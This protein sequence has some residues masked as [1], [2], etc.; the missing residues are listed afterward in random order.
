[1]KDTAP[2]SQQ[3]QE[4]EQHEVREVLN[5]LKRYGKLIGAG[6]L[7]AVVTVLV[8]RGIASHRAR[9]AAEAD[10]MLINAR[11]PAELQAVVENYSSTPSAP[12]A[13]LDLAKTLFNEGSTVQ[14]RENYELFLKKYGRHE[15][16]PAAEIGLAYCTEAEGDLNGAMEQFRAF[17]QKNEDSYLKPMAELGT[18]R[19]LE[20]LGRREEARIALE[21]FLAANPGS[22][23]TTRA[24]DALQRLTR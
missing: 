3:H 18:A 8:S 17:V 22:A 19:C 4:L 1:M 12:A 6:V 16:R 14:A 15:L 9:K 5:F 24:E 13:L 11:T 2:H 20:Q 10:Q 23:W 7:A 21:D